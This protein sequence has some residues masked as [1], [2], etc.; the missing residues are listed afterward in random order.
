MSA[1]KNEII[2][3]ENVRQ[4]KN[5]SFA[6]I[7]KLF[8]S[9]IM[10]WVLVLAIWSIAASFSDPQFLPGPLAVWQGAVDL[11]QDG[12]LF[13]YIWVSFLRVITGWILGNLVAIP[14]GLLVGRVPMLRAIFDPIINFVRFIPPLAFITLFMLWFG[15]GEQS[16][17]SLFCMRLS[18]SLR[19]TPLRACRRW[20]KIKFD[21]QEVWVPPS[22]KSWFMS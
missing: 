8:K 9:G 17:S 20:K 4:K 21:Q 5:P 16:K 11:S 2:E 22:G 6:L 1:V 18:L 12:S 15:I 14:I 10:A 7:K 13:L 19:S 3:Q